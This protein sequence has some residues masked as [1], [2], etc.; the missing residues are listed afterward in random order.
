MRELKTGYA[1]HGNRMPQHKEWELCFR[2]AFIG[3]A[4]FRCPLL[5]VYQLRMEVVS[6]P[7]QNNRHL[8]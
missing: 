7:Y 1:Y 2:L 5:L 8:L 3:N 6:K 4:W